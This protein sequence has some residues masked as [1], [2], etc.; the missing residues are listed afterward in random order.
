MQSHSPGQLGRLVL[1]SL[2]LV[3]EIRVINHDHF[4]HPGGLATP[5]TGGRRPPPLRLWPPITRSRPTPTHGRWATARLPLQGQRPATDGRLG[6]ARHRRAVRCPH[7]SAVAALARRV[8]LFA[9]PNRAVGPQTMPFR[10]RTAHVAVHDDVGV[11][12]ARSALRAAPAHVP[13]VAVEG[14]QQAAGDLLREVKAPSC[15][16][17]NHRMKKC[18]W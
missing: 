17:H 16:P 8:I 14:L 15:S 7:R 13:A 1:S 18:S 5:A 10:F 3:P 9:L 6:S 12:V 4:H 11:A 2:G